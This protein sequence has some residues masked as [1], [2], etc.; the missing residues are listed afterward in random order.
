[1]KFKAALH[2]VVRFLKSRITITVLGLL[3]LALLIWFGGPL[4]AIA[5]YE[6]LATVTARLVTLLVIAIIWGGSHYIKGLKEARSHRQAVDTLLNGDEQQPQ[7]ELAKRDIAVLRERMQKALDILKHARFSKS[8]DIYQLPWYMLIGPPGSGKTTALQNSGLEFPLKEQL[9]DDAIEGIAGT[10]QCDWWF[11]NQ[12]VLIDTAGRYTTQD[13]HASQDS[14]A[15]QGFLGLLRKYR[16]KQPINGVI[17]F[18]SL[19]DLLSQTR[20]ERHLHARAIKQ[21]VQE[22]QN[23][24]GMTFPVYV[25]FTKADLIAGFTEFF[26]NM[27]EEEREQV[28]GMTFTIEHDEKGAV[29]SFNKEFHNMINRLT[30]RLFHRLQFEHDQDNRAAIY[31]FPR[32]LRLLQSAADDFLKEIFAPNPFEK[33]TMLRGVYIASAT[34]EGVPIDRVM[35][36]L[37]NNFGLAEPPMRRQT[38]EGESYFIK[39]FFEEIVIPEHELASVNL[40]HKNKHRWIRHGVLASSALISIWLL[41][42]WSG[43]YSWNKQLVDEVS[44]SISQYQHLA[45]RASIDENIVDLNHQLNLLRDLPAGYSG[46]IPESGPKNYGLYQGDKLGQAGK[47]AY[48]NGLYNKFVP[49]LLNSLIDEMEHNSEHRDYL[50][51]TLKTYLMLFN[52]DKFDA[53]Q[54]NT[55]F[56]VYLEH[57]F[58]GTVNKDLRSSLQSHLAALLESHIKGAVYNESAVVAAR[59]LLLTVPLAERAYQRIK[60]E[61]I[62]SHIPDFRVIDVLGSDSIKIFKRK[63]GLPLQQGISGLYTYKGFH[64]LFNIEKRRIIRSLMEDS[65]VYGEGV[66]DGNEQQSTDSTLSKQVTAKYFRDYIYVWQELLDDLTLDRVVNLE[67]G[68]FVTKVLT[69]PEQPIQNIIK[70]V[71]ENVRLTHLPQSDEADMALD[72]AGKVAATSFSSQKS[73][74]TRIMPDNMPNLTKSLPG[75]EVEY[76]FDTI[77][78]LGEAQFIQIEK[79]SRLYHEYLER[80]YMPG[81]IAKQAYSN[82]LNG[83][84]SNELSVAIRRLKSDIPPPF[85]DWLGDISTE[86]TQ[87]FAQGSRQ[88][89]NEAWKGTVLAEYKRAIAGRYPLNKASSDDIKLRDFERF[90]G[91]GGTLEQFFSEYLKPFVNTSRSTWTFK[92]DIGL[93]HKVLRTFQNAEKIRTAFFAEGSQ[94][95]NVGFSLRPVYLDRHITHLLLELDGQELSYSH[96]PSRFRQFSWPGDR[97]KLQTRIVFTPAKAG[98]PANTSYA[99]EWSWFRFIDNVT[100]NRADTKDDKILHL[101]V[102]GNHAHVELVPDTVNNPFWNK[103]LEAFS[104]PATL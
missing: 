7:D 91:Y 65:W 8:R 38:G 82:Q 36:Q 14:T 18:V 92:K 43:S 46:V 32:Q 69:G 73:R 40:H 93:D 49:F 64:G 87:L 6:P 80:L 94:K 62:K 33:P 68:V 77:L 50:Y 31:E 78:K 23:Q 37:G 76:A 67:D 56:E 13:S 74:L 19:A 79:T 48:Q 42:S 96:G 44:G 4:L 35:S 34:Q 52:Q 103:A 61:L 5:G 99:G 100:Q 54:L 1:M 81:G 22:L 28:W 15:W 83:E 88:H 66:Q 51:E 21:R 98:L 29:S 55:W 104:C 84:G 59:E 16:P 30:Q 95:L 3:A 27:S 17:I 97:N 47:T 71:Q 39:R 41:F 53:I 20:T 75:K 101:A 9:G 63:S 58:S 60:S 72:V 24:L 12:A 45:D 25:M 70:A 102:Q 85:S 90:F 57:R 89:I 26:R 11:T 10:R 2:A 86:T